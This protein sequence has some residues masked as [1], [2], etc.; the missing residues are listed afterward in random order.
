LLPGLITDKFVLVFTSIKITIIKDELMRNVLLLVVMLSFTTT[1][2]A[3]ESW[4]DSVLSA[5][6][7]GDDTSEQV[8]GPSADGLLDSVTSNLGVT[9]EQAKGGIAALVNYVKQNISEEQFAKLS[10]QIPGLDSVMQYLPEVEAVSKG[11]LSG[12][13]DKAA[14]YSESLGDLNDLNKQF[15]SLGLNT[16][17]IKDYVD[18]AK[19]YLDTPEGEEAKQLLTDGLFKI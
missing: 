4:W 3:Q 18:Q 1:A 12:L 19:S 10:A 6:G 11:G 8:T 9:S 5:V 16:A 17:M 2:I 13:M 14:E 7:L 15:E